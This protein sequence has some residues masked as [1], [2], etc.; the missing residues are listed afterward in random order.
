MVCIAVEFFE[1]KDLADM[2]K[3]GHLLAIPKVLSIVASV[4]EALVYAH[5]QKAVHRDIKPA[6]IMYDS[7]SGTV[8]VNDFGIARITDSGKT[9][10]GLVLGAPSF[11]TPEQIAGKKVDGRSGLYSLGVMLFQKL[12]GALPF[13]GDSMGELMYKIA[14]KDGPDIRIIR[15]ELPVRL[16]DIVT[17]SI[18]K[19]PET[20]YQDGDQFAADLRAFTSE[21]AAIPA[22]ATA[23]SI[24]VP[25]E[26]VTDTKKTLASSTTEQLSFEKT[27]AAQARTDLKL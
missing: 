21:S 3:D 18:G 11:M 2:T 15:S 19:K 20:R 7:D 5:K 1:S 25:G 26:P 6:N 14:D 13:R 23:T 17:L 8:K 12:T 10:T 9:K 16:A 4:A 27:I 22:A 24:A